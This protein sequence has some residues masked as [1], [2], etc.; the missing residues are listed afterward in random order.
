MPDQ[1]AKYVCDQCGAPLSW[2]PSWRFNGEMWE[3]RCAH[4]HP[5]AGHLGSPIPRPMREYITELEGDLSDLIGAFS[6][7]SALFE[8]LD[9]EMAGEPELYGDFVKSHQTA[10]PIIERWKQRKF[11]EDSHA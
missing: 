4:H 3:H 1:S 10:I 9:E 8:A 5:Q 2:D 7:L 11:G 6:Q